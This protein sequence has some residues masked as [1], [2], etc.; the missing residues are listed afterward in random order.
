M[1]TSTSCNMPERYYSDGLTEKW[2][3]DKNKIHITGW[4]SWNHCSKVQKDAKKI[5]KL[6]LSG[7]K[8]LD[9]YLAK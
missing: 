1:V 9:H 5:V 3:L 7:G 4:I 2:D 6:Q 8:F